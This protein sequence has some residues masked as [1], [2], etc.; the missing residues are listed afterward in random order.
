LH[1]SISELHLLG[2][3]NHA[4]FTCNFLFFQVQFF[5]TKKPT[6][7]TVLTLL[8]NVGYLWVLTTKKKYLL[9][10]VHHHSCHLHRNPL[11]R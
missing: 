8:S 11:R 6:P 3:T 4:Y 5:Q 7:I 1:L 2:C 10:I 9:L